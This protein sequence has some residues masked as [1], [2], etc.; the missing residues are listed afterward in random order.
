MGVSAEKATSAPGDGLAAIGARLDRLGSSVTLWVLVLALSL[1]GFF[2]AYL[3]SSGPVIV[4]GMVESGLL[5]KGSR[6]ADSLAEIFNLHT[7]AGFFATTYAGLWVA[8]FFFGFIADKFG[9]RTVF[10]VGLLW[11][12]IAGAIM[13]FQETASGLIFW[14]FLLAIGAGIEVIT[15]DS[16]LSELMPKDAR[17]KAFAVNNA[18]H[19]AGKP[20]ATL[21]AFALSMA[22]TSGVHQTL[23]GLEGWRW[24]V[25]VGSVG[26]IVV[27]PL[28]LLIPESPRWLAAHGKLAEA[29]KVVSRL[30]AR[31]ERERGKP[32]PP[33]EP[34]AKQPPHKHGRFLEMF[35]PEYLPRT[36]MLSVFHLLQAIALHGFVNWMPTLL[37]SHGVTITE[38][39]G[40]TFAM[41]LV[42]PL[43][44]LACIWFAD[45][46]ERKW[47]IVA[48]AIVVALC[49]FTFTLSRDPLIIVPAGALE[50][51]AASVLN[52]AFHAYQ[53]ELF[54]TRI[55]VQGVGFVYSW[56]RVSA[57]LSGFL[58]AYIL[59]K[60]G[61]PAVF[62]LFTGSMLTL[63]LFITFLG[64]RTRGQSLE[65]LS[66]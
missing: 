45:K 30:E 13:A 57:A 64:P 33:P 50:L 4:P 49:G 56:S 41:T 60:Y 65:T 21:A 32:L 15:I 39:L 54:P 11:F 35:G 53:A 5:A 62:V 55:R 8:A 12:S 59:G 42:A 19:S 20:I 40:Y 38:S 16:Y 26:A 34:V 51:L 1:G 63:A 47:Q 36:V 22:M 44:P 14:R 17:G 10:T 37:V 7:T 31:V 3:L 61:T 24:V 48:S 18:I 25:L 28:R 66:P 27:W 23:F 58:V 43:G 9:R 6:H 29:E 46:V 52:F 2:D